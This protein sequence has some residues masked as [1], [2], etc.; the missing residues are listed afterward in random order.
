M[1]VRR[2]VA[3]LAA[4]I[5][6][7][8]GVGIGLLV[9]SGSEQPKTL[10]QADC[11]AYPLSNARVETIHDPL[12][13]A[14]YHSRVPPPD[15]K[16]CEQGFT[17]KQ[18]ALAIINGHLRDSQL[19][20]IYRGRLLKGP[21]A[22]SWNAMNVLARAPPSRGGCG[23]TLYPV[24]P[25]S[26]YR[27]YAAQYYLW[28]H[29]PHAYDRRWKAF[30]GTSLHGYGRA[31]DLASYAMRYCV[32]KI[33]SRFGWGKCDAPLEWWHV[34]DC[35]V[36]RYHGPDPGPLGNGSTST[37]KGHR[38]RVRGHCRPILRKGSHGHP[39]AVRLVQRAMRKAGYCSV[40]VDGHYGQV[41]RRAVKRYQRRHHVHADGIVG[42]RTWKKIERTRHTLS[43]CR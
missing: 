8:A 16:V 20:P 1:Q 5:V 6:L 39:G 28:T 35:V 29:W 4:L 24:G 42:A 13:G 7:V 26:S 9:N 30:P 32:N 38:V 36:G 19:S 27:S 3:A 11:P 10:T 43:R 17:P 22:A 18:K 21:I 40:K 12:T 14:T 23:L 31:V 15:A 25:I 41:T 2:H 34:V 37:C 33:G